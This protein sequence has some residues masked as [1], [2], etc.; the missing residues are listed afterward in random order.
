MAQNKK[1]KVCKL[2]DR[3]HEKEERLGER[4]SVVAGGADDSVLTSSKDVASEVSCTK[5]RHVSGFSGPK[6][7]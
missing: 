7:P 2:E 6:V 5:C 4:E 3:R 1:H